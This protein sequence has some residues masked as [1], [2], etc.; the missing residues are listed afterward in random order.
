MICP[1]A[2]V[3]AQQ[4]EKTMN[5]KACAGKQRKCE[6]KLSNHQALPQAV[7][8]GACTRPAPFLERFR[9]IDARRYQAGALPNS[10]PATAV[11]ATV[12]SRMGMFSC[13][14]ASSGTCHPA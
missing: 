8:A 1:G 11:A 14:L 7:P 10:R 2:Q 12:N 5:G 13:R 4:V 3:N 9:R 6:G